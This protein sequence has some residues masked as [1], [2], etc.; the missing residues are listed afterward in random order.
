MSAQGLPL[1]VG[2]LLVSEA[3]R[4]PTLV[5]LWAPALWLTWLPVFSAGSWDGG[6][7]TRT[8]RWWLRVKAGK[9]K[10][11][12]PIPP[13]TPQTGRSPGGTR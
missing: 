9:V 1:V 3:R 11:D 6:L 2:R 13:L 10:L 12:P 4:A 7:S 5:C 8:P